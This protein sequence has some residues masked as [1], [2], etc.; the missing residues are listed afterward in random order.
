LSRAIVE[1]RENHREDEMDFDN[2]SRAIVE[3]RENH[4][5]DEM[6]FDNLSRAIVEERRR[7]TKKSKGGKKNKRKTRKMR[8]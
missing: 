8:R 2:L 6:D 5:E 1:E 7:H 3:E 4:R